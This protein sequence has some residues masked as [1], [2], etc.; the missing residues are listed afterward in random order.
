MW[1]IGSR[2]SGKTAEVLKIVSGLLKDNPKRVVQFWQ[3]H[4]ELIENIVK[5]CPEEFRGR[6]ETI[7]KLKQIKVNSIFVIDE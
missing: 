4:R 2:G 6:F 5:V 7:F 3:A 1:I